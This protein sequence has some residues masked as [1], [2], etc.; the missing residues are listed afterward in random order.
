MKNPTAYVA[1]IQ[2]RGYKDPLFTAEGEK[3]EDPVAFLSTMPPEEAGREASAKKRKEQSG[4]VPAAK[5][6]KT[7]EDSM[8]F[9]EDGTPIK[10]PVAYVAGIAMRGYKD[11]L[12]DANGT[13]IKNPIAYVS[14]MESWSGD[15][16]AANWMMMQMQYAPPTSNAG[17]GG[18]YTA[19][20]SIV[21]NP[22]A[23]LEGIKKNGY[24]QPL[25]GAD[26]KPIRNPEAY[27]D[28]MVKRGQLSG[29][30]VAKE[31]WSQPVA[32][33]TW[34]EKPRKNSGGG[35]SGGLFKADG[36]Q[37]RNPKAYAAGIEKRGHNEPLYDSAGVEI[38]NPVAY[39]AAMK[40]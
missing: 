32:K 27:I 1:G 17:G 7:R 29:K 21:K 10:N 31:A 18:I 30:P 6:K 40:N 39:I 26:G 14:K 36:T 3:I 11:P 20:G 8:L 15:N 5:R 33:Q 37:I 19:D 24:T 13:K 22:L 16:S 4:E 28:A 2:K 38:R 25:F 23:Y 9:K 12:F 34:S 35:K